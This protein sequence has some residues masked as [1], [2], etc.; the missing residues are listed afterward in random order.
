VYEVDPYN[1]ISP[2]MAFSSALLGRECSACRR[3]LPY[4]VFDRDSSTKDGRALICP[5]CKSTPRLSAAENLSRLQE[6]NFSSEAVKAQRR[7][8]EEFYLE[9]DSIGRGME[10]SE[11]IFKLKKIFGTK[12]VVGDAFFLNEFSLYLNDPSKTETN[13]VQYIGF[14]P[15]GFIQEF[16]SYEYN[17]KLVPVNETSRGYRG[18]LLKLILL[19]YVTETQVEKVFGVCD[20]KVWCKTLHNWRSSKI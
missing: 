3:A 13:G 1:Q 16:S 14:I 12:L 19:G 5:K 17:D 2:E 11:F 6:A 15:S 9:R 10:H 8:D 7:P 4:A 18:I 20:E